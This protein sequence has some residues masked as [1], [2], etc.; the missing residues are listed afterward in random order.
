M[1]KPIDTLEQAVANLHFKSKS[2]SAYERGPTKVV[3]K[4]ALRLDGVDKATGKTKYGQDLFEK[5]Y[6][7]AKVLRAAYP[8]AEVLGIDTREAKKMPGVLAVLT[9]QDMP[10]TNMHGLIR[11]DQEVLCGKKVRY[12]GDAVAIVVAKDE[13]AAVVASKKIKVDYRPLPAV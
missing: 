12:L 2:S 5:S 10:G 4:S 13:E 1:T 6:L 9:H 3:G 8:H 11:R 7:S